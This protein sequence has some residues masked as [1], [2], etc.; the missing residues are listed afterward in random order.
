[1][2]PPL[3]QHSLLSLGSRVWLGDYLSAVWTCRKALLV[4]AGSARLVESWG[5]CVSPTPISFNT[6]LMAATP[7]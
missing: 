3:K 1:M 6:D 2:Y 7:T 4:G 5:L